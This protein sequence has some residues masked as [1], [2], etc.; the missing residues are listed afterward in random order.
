MDPNV[1]DYVRPDAPWQTALTVSQHFTNVN[2][3]GA[4]GS[5]LAAG[6]SR[7]AGV[8]DDLFFMCVNFT[9][10]HPVD[11]ATYI[12]D[13]QNKTWAVYEPPEKDWKGTLT[14]K[15][16]SYAGVRV[17]LPTTIPVDTSGVIGVR[18]RNDMV[19]AERIG[20]HWILR[21]PT[22]AIAEEYEAW[23]QTRDGAGA[24]RSFGG[25][26]ILFDMLGTWTISIEMLM[27]PD[28]PEIVDDFNGDILCAAEEGLF[29]GSIEDR[30]LTVTLVGKSQDVAI[31]GTIRPTSPL[32]VGYIPTAHVSAVGQNNM[33]TTQSMGM[34]WV[35]KKP[36]GGIVSEYTT[37]SYYWVEV[38]PGL[39]GQFTGLDFDLDMYGIWTI[40]MELLMNP[41]DPIVV[42]SYSDQMVEVVEPEAP[43]EG[44][45]FNWVPYAIGAGVIL[46]LVLLVRK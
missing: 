25:G 15:D 34:H 38:A 27:N 9:N 43:P 45:G 41:G 32:R 26:D 31:P 24:E 30:R 44:E 4:G 36:S 8:E 21:D 29:S 14:L 16:L 19:T 20:V 10:P 42:D 11:G 23:G 28:S 7:Y 2:E 33:D 3:Y 46:G 5:W 12:Y 37:P 17:S 22:G 39:Y 40:E 18:G 6:V 1:G 13:I 35:V